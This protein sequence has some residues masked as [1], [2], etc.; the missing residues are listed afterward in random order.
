MAAL[1]ERS[2][3]NAAMILLPTV[4]GDPNA[5]SGMVPALVAPVL[6]SARV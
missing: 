3:E 6:F 4:T 5:G 1:V 2:Q